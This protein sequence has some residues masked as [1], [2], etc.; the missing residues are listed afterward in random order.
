[1]KEPM[2]LNIV[3]FFFRLRLVERLIFLVRFA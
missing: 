1:M 2:M 3:K